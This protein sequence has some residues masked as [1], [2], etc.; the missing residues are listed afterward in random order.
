MPYETLHR[1]KRRHPL[2]EIYDDKIAQTFGIFKDQITIMIHTGSRG[3]GHQVCTDYVQLMNKNIPKFGFKLVDREL[4]CAPFESAEGQQY[5]KAMAAA[6]NFAWVNRQMICDGIRNVWMKILGEDKSQLRLLYDV[7]HNIAKIETYHGQKFIVHRKGATR[8]F[9]PHHTELPDKYKA[10]GQPVIIPGSMG[11]HSYILVG[12]QEAMDNSFGS[13]CHGAGRR[14]SRMKSKKTVSYRD[15]Q[16][17][18]DKQGIIVRAGSIRGLVEE[19]PEAYKNIDDVVAV[20]DA[21]KIARKIAKLKP[22]A[23]VKG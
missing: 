8:A 7:A 14:M 11:T 18:L 17:N 15:L 13:T 12:T 10:T 23:V 16:E 4:A 6:A 19:A 9:A 3:L 5:L 1:E 21:E 22:I 20:V 2:K